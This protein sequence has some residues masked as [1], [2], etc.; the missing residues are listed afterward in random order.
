MAKEQVGLLLLIVHQSLLHIMAAQQAV[1]VDPEE[2]QADLVG[3]IIQIKLLEMAELMV[4]EVAVVG[5]S[6][7]LQAEHLAQAA[8]EQ[9]I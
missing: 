1:G 8:M 5:F 6:S 3:I 4:V 9:F 7:L 2:R